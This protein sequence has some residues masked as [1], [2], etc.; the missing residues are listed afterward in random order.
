LSAERATVDK[1]FEDQGQGMRHGWRDNMRVIFERKLEGYISYVSLER[2][3]RLYPQF[4]VVL[5]GTSL[6]RQRMTAPVAEDGSIGVPKASHDAA[7]SFPCLILDVP[8]CAANLSA[9]QRVAGGDRYREGKSFRRY[10]GGAVPP[11][12]RALRA[13]LARYR[14]FKHFVYIEMKSTRF[15]EDFMDWVRV[16]DGE[17]AP[18]EFV[19]PT[20]DARASPDERSSAAE[21]HLRESCSPG[22]RYVVMRGDKDS[23]RAHRDCLRFFNA[24]GNA[25]GDYIS[26]VFGGRAVK[27]GVDLMTTNYVH[28]LQPP[29][30]SSTLSQVARRA[31][32]RCSF[33]YF[34]DGNVNRWFVS[35]IIY[36]TVGSSYESVCL[37]RCMA[38][39]DTPV[40]L[41]LA[42]MKSAAVDCRIYANLTG[43][44]CGPSSPAPPEGLAETGTLCVYPRKGAA[45]PRLIS[46]SAGD[47]RAQFTEAMCIASEGIPGA[48]LRYDSHDEILYQLLH[49]CGY[50]P[51]PIQPD[52]APLLPADF[53]RNARGVSLRAGVWLESATAEPVLTFSRD[54][55]PEVLA[56]WIQSNP[57]RVGDAVLYL[58]ASKREAAAAAD[59]DALQWLATACAKY[60]ERVHVDEEGHVDL[61]A[62]L[63]SMRLSGGASAHDLSRLKSIGITVQKAGKKAATMTRSR[64]A[65]R[66][67]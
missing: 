62:R 27:E 20:L 34:D 56:G 8:S 41:A 65:G 66:R 50:S 12:W 45:A 35:V 42:A 9:E 46:V 47:G 17:G 63:L 16:V 51:A 23:S 43:I 53:A 31:A 5:D 59:G 48:L 7:S 61:V 28:V 4:R 1:W 6:P 3:P 37:D 22:Y 24:R 49:S 21:A 29:S 60:V 57:R 52:E 14:G 58:L 11:K 36:R 2:D 26:I 15:L 55:L 38:G 32:R 25:D 67:P 13:F 39:P 19:P 64:P 54:T 44:R 40:E 18:R 30:R 10:S 33:R